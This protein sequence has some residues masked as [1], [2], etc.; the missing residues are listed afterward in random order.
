VPDET[1]LTQ[2]G[3]STEAFRKAPRIDRELGVSL[4]VGEQSSEAALRYVLAGT[5]P[6]KRQLIQASR[7]LTKAGALRVAG[8]AVVHTPGR[9]K[10]GIHV[11]VVWPGTEPLNRQDVPWPIAVSELFDTCFNDDRGGGRN[12]P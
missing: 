3:W 11:T 6:S 9:V 4:L 1:V 5:A 12:E 7:R 8:F 10:G 2:F